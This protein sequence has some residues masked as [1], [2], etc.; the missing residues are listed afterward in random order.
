MPK[1]VSAFQRIRQH[2]LRPVLRISVLQ[3]C[4]GLDRCRD[5]G[6]DGMGRWIGWG[7]VAGNLERIARTVAARQPACVA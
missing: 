7:I 5:H 3:R 2:L 4:Y 1:N 6:E